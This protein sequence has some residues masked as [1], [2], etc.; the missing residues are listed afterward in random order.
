M[1]THHEFTVE[2][3]SDSGELNG[4]YAHLHVIRAYTIEYAESERSRSRSRPPAGLDQG[5]MRNFTNLNC[6]DSSSDESD[7]DD[8]EVQAMLRRYRAERRQRRMTSGSVSKRTISE[9]IGSDTDREDL[10]GSFS[11]ED[12]NS[13]RRIRRKLCG[14]RRR[15][16]FL[17]PT[18]PAPRIDELEEPDSSVEEIT[19]GEVL[20][21]EL[22][23]YEYVTMEVDSS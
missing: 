7:M 12:V 11:F 2:E 4:K 10:V 1:V 15:G 16:S 17:F 14:D 20:A 18:P 5:M 19:I 13:T 22:P 8:G 3:L 9:S 23:Y 21:R 6:S